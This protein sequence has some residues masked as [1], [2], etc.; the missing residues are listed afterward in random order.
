MQQVNIGNGL[1]VVSEITPALTPTLTINEDLTFTGTGNCNTFAGTLSFE[2]PNATE[3]I[4]P[5][6]TAL[7]SD[8][9]NDCGTII[10][11]SLEHFTS[12][13][14]AY[15]TCVGSMHSYS[16]E[17]VTKGKILHVYTPTFGGATFK[18]FIE[19]L[20]AKKI[21]QVQIEV[22]PNPASTLIQIQSPN[23]AILKI[24]LFNSFGQKVKTIENNFQPIDIS[25]LSKGF[26][27]LK[28]ETE[29]GAINK[30]IVKN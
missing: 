21:N 12:F 28:I 16:I 25:S 26:Y 1:H 19:D 17:T 6:Q 5:I 23:S 20:S 2:S 24:E 14:R 3:T 8:T 18:N 11:G 22:Y 30:R 4:K 10:H 9:K 27:I 7:F 15:F 29:V 13:E